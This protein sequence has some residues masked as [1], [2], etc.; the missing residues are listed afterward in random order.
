MAAL[1]NTQPQ[2]PSQHAAEPQTANRQSPAMQKGLGKKDTAIAERLQKLKDATK[3]G[4][5]L[6]L[7]LLNYYVTVC[8]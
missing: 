2:R 1:E 3:P 5:T 7:L 8:C 4:F 6:L